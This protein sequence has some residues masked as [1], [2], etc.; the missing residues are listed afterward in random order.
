MFEPLY[1]VYFI[2]EAENDLD[3]LYDFFLEPGKEEFAIAERALLAIENAIAQLKYSPFSYRKAV[4]DN[5]YIREIIIPFGRT[6]YLALFEIN[7]VEQVVWILAL[8]HQREK[9]YFR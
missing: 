8:R 6:G 7:P 9:D 2:P 5:I 3:Y 1:N 4:D